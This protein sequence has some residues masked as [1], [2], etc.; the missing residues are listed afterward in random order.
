LFVFA[1]RH[2]EEGTTAID[3]D[4]SALCGVAGALGIGIGGIR[5]MDQ[6]VAFDEL[7]A[8]RSWTASARALHRAFDVLFPS[9]VHNR[10]RETFA[11]V[12]PKIA[13]I[14]LAQPHSLVVHRLKHRR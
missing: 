5:D 8:D 4:H 6:I 3:I 10:R 13:D 2:C 12:G 9:V 11:V 7:S 1:Q 14:G